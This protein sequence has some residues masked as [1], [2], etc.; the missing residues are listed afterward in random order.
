MS[1]LYTSSLASAFS[2]F[3]PS[4]GHASTR[5][6]PLAPRALQEESRAPQ[7]AAADAD[8]EIASSTGRSSETEAP[9]PTSYS[10]RGFLCSMCL[11]VRMVATRGIDQ[12][13]AEVTPVKDVCK[14]CGGSGAVLCDMCGGTGKWKALNRKRAKD[15]YEFT[16]CPNCYGRGKLVCPICFGTGIAN[17]KGLLRRPESKPLLDK[18]YNGQLLPSM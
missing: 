3:I 8:E 13:H 1:S 14:N 7:V 15:V 11:G 12:A 5:A 18:M 6:L 4:N 16:E 17:N 9:V 2:A 10:R